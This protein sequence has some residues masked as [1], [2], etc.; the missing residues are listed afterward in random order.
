MEPESLSYDAAEYVS[1][2]RIIVERIF[3]IL[4]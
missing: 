1:N 2:V 4:L 3:V